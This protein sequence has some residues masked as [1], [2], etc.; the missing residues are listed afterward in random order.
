MLRQAQCD[1]SHA[2]VHPVNGKAGPCQKYPDKF[3]KLIALGVH[4]ELD[5]VKWRAKVAKELDITATMEGLISLTDHIEAQGEGV[6][7]A[8]DSLSKDFSIGGSRE[9]SVFL[10]TSLTDKIPPF[11][12]LPRPRDLWSF[13]HTKMKVRRTCARSTRA[14]SS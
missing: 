8:I 11:P 1:H 6:Q 14:R 2:H 5:D 3:V 4:R 9:P 12:Y 13:L 10:L 7:G